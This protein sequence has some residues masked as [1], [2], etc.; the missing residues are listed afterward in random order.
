MSNMTKKLRKGHFHWHAVINGKM[1]DDHTK[2]QLQSTA[3]T[4]EMVWSDRWMEGSLETG[5]KFHT[6]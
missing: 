4:V 5:N 1:S 6:I 3:I 2:K